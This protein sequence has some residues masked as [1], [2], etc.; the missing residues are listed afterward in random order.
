M[1]LLLPII[2]Y[3]VV[4]NKCES[5]APKAVDCVV[6]V[7]VFVVVVILVVNVVVVALLVVTFQSI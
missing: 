6:D 5:E 4:V 2:S 1:L 7:I 3:L